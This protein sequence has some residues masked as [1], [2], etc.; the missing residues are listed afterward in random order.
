MVRMM[1]QKIL[2]DH[3]AFRRLG[4]S[5]RKRLLQAGELW[6]APSGAVLYHPG[7]AA[8]DLLCVLEGRLQC[9]ETGKSWLPGDLWGEESIAVPESVGKQLK[10]AEYSRWLRWTRSSLLTLASE[11]QRMRAD[12]APLRGKDRE[13]ISGL[14]VEIPNIE[15]S[16]SGYKIHRSWKPLIVPGLICLITAVLLAWA[17]SNSVS[18]PV[19]FFLISPAF[20]LLW[21]IVFLVMQFFNSY[22]FSADAISSRS[23]DWSRFS[24]ESRYVPMDQVQGVVSK[25]N[26]LSRRLFGYGTVIVKTSAAEGDVIFKDVNSPGNIVSSIDRYKRLQKACSDGRERES[27]RRILEKNQ[28][29]NRIPR[30]IQSSQSSKPQAAGSNEFRFRKSLFVLFGR[31]FLPLLTMLIPILGADILISMLPIS[32]ITAMGMALIPGLWALYRYEDWRNDIFTISGNYV[33]D[34]YRKPLGLKET[35]KQVDINSI[36]NIRTEQKGPAALLFRYG[37]VILVTVGGASDAI[38]SNVSR[39]WKVQETLFRHRENLR[40]QREEA[41]RNNRKEELIRFAEAL[42]QIAE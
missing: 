30:M 20:F 4:T 29:G 10:A 34:I 35:R 28:I 38:F 27:M 40:R 22:H 37:D 31:L 16:N 24:I 39:P 26:G 33:I 5:D 6:E 3:P 1:K 18:L 15:P 25:R 12:L 23:L 32:R 14:S 11:S 13:L 17:G 19:K 42:E 41:D 36:Q 8:E 7:D 9:N 21:I 2:P